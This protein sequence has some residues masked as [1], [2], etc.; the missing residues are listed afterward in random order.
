MLHG[1]GGAHGTFTLW[2]LQLQLTMESDKGITQTT[3]SGQSARRGC[4]YRGEGADCV[5]CC[6]CNCN[7]ATGR[8]R[9]SERC[10]SRSNNCS[11]QQLLP[12]QSGSS[13]RR[14]DLQCFQLTTSSLLAL[15]SFKSVASHRPNLLPVFPLSLLSHTHLVSSSSPA[16]LPSF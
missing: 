13:T 9:E 10:Q 12:L 6:K 1:A 4:V 2:P 14:L 16:D 8:R 7:F 5:N 3:R 15:L 11:I